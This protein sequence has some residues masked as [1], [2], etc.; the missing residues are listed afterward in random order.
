LTDLNTLIRD[1]S[2]QL[3]QANTINDLGQIAGVGYHDGQLHAFLLTVP[4]PGN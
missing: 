3:I 2:W 1:A 4:E